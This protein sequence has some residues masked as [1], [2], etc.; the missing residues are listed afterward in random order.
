MWNLQDQVC[1]QVCHRFQE[2]L[3]QPPS[4]FCLHPRTGTLLIGTNQVASL[5]IIHSHSLSLSLSW[6]SWSLVEMTRSR[7]MLE[8][9]RLA[10]H[11]AM[12]G[13]SPQLYLMPSSTRLAV[14]S[15]PRSSCIMDLSLSLSQQVVSGCQGVWSVCGISTREKRP[16]NSHVAMEIW[17]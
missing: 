17:N 2:L 13:L 9:G 6:V 16:C 5:A 10:R 14:P 12:R 15:L 11:S 4:A 1:L 3:P 7:R 8:G